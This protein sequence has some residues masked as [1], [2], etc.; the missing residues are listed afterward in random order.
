[1]PYR[2]KIEQ[3][4]IPEPFYWP[5]YGDEPLDMSREE[6]EAV[7]ADLNRMDRSRAHWAEQTG[8]ETWVGQYEVEW[9]KGESRHARRVRR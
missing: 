5:G 7:V 2:V 3:P 9:V 6:A 1:M 8:R 4:S